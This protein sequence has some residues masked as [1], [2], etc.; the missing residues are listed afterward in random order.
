MGGG[1]DMA[2]VC[3]CVGDVDSCVRFM[4][5][6]REAWQG[7]FGTKKGSFLHLVQ[8]LET[9]CTPPPLVYL[10]QC[11]MSS[12]DSSSSNSASSGSSSSNSASSSSVSSSHASVSSAASSR[13]FDPLT[14]P[15]DAL[16]DAVVDF[17]PPSLGW[18]HVRTFLRSHSIEETKGAIEARGEFDTTAL[19]VACRNDPPADVVDVMIMAAPDMIYWADSFGW[20]PLHYA[21][22]S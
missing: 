10:D 9:R 15:L 6:E 20:L 7:S 21:C 4:G 11:N 3:V 16:I 5:R 1:W 2:D 19:H 18:E 22:A 12:S 8:I 17:D 14:A 13:E